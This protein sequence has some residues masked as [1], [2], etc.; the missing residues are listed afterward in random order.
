MNLKRLKRRKRNWKELLVIKESRIETGEMCEM[1]RTLK[2]RGSRPCRVLFSG[3]PRNLLGGVN[4]M[5]IIIIIL[6]ISL[7]NSR[8]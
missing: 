7:V 8:H 4:I 3:L 2:R 6:S 5:I 1:W